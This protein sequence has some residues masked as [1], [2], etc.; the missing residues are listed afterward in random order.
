MGRMIFGMALV[1]A[2]SACSS[3]SAAPSCAQAIAHYYS[4][5]CAFVNLETGEVSTQSEATAGC[6][7]ASGQTPNRC[8]GEVDDWLRCVNETSTKEQCDCSEEQMAILRCE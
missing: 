6:Q 2:L 8:D 3:E 1:A 4:E 7:A 5:G